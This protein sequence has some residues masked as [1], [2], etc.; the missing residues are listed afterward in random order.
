MQIFV[1][2]KGFVKVYPMGGVGE[3]TAVLR[4]FTKDVEMLKI[5]V[6]DPH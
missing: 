1:S 3:F 6:A 4:E 2:D 5:L